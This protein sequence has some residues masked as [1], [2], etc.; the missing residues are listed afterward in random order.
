MS[1]ID[2]TCE[3][4]LEV[5]PFVSERAFLRMSEMLAGIKMGG[6]AAE[7]AAL[8]LKETLSTTTA[9][10]AF[11]HAISSKNLEDWDKA[12]RQ[13]TK[14]ADVETVDDFEPVTFETLRWNVGEDLKYGKGNKGN[15]GVSPIVA[16]GDT[17]QYTFGY[18]EE[19][20]SAALQKRGFKVG[21]LTLERILSRLRPLVRQLPADM[22]DIALN[23]DEFLVFDALQ[24]SVVTGTSLKAG[25]APV[26]GASVP[27][28]AA[29]SID[30]LRLGLTQIT[31]R[32]VAD[33]KVTLAS[34]YYIVVASGYGE[35]VQAELD[36][37]KLLRQIVDPASG[38]PQ[39]YYG[40]PSLGNLGKIAGVIESEW[41]TSDTAWYVVPAAGTSK[42]PGLKK[43][44]L[45]GRTAPEVLVN[46]FTGTVISGN[47]GDAFDLAHF[48]NDVVDLKLRQFTNS[49]LITQ[50]QIVWSKGTNAA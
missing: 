39:F 50:D 20:V 36:K 33:R 46:N 14:I 9:P 37:A 17:Y 38:S 45:A 30:A 28:N 15:A 42:R 41:I 10:F 49:A 11:A 23:T 4:R 24:S 7:R 5:H 29:F 8:D 32:K 19:S 31:Q 21:D 27:I 1:K 26:S 18:S 43:L 2:L 34:S 22:L 3:N 16:E 47:G 35:I 6:F 48:D 40:A 44:Q 13:W 25:T 12:E